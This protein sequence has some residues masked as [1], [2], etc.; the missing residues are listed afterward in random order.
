VLRPI[1]EDFYD[2]VFAD[3]MIGFFFE[4]KDK[5][6]LVEK[7]LELSLVVFGADPET[8][9]GRPLT[10][11]HAKH[12]IMGGHFARRTQIL[13]DTLHDHGFDAAWTQTWLDHTEA[14]RP[15]ITDY[16]GG[17]CE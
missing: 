11:A 5:A 4:G 12:P 8:Y 17:D 6:R 15:Q 7:E 13:K 10:K 3:V 14:L 9:T 2:R 1:L 16:S